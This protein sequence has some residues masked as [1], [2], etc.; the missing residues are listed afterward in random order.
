MDNQD[1]KRELIIDAA[2]KRFAHFGLAKTTMTEI[3]SDISL[4]K[5][6]LYYYFPDKITLYAAV[7]EHLIEEITLDIK[8]GMEKIEDSKDALDF[9]LDKRHDYLKK[10][11]TIFEFIRASSPDI[12]EQ[13]YQ[14]L[15]KAKKNEVE[16]IAC[17]IAK[18][19]QLSI[20]SSEAASLLFD[21]FVGMR[22]PIFHSS[23]TFQ[24][25]PEVFE[26]LL[27]RQKKLGEIFL[28][29]L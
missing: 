18:K 24:I 21:A 27:Q 1:K 20:D 26:N 22:I 2:L 5:A 19:K 7:V 12:P 29:G 11:Y 14:T 25:D 28:R 17:A 9:Y 3:A 16:Q 13:L 23:K 15:L 8:K 10:Y 6:L 4:S